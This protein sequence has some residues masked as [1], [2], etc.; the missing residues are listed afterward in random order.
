MVNGRLTK[1]ISYIIL[2]NEIQIQ[3]TAIPDRC[4]GKYGERLR[5][6]AL[7]DQ[8]AV[9]PRLGQAETAAEPIKKDYFELS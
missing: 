8:L 6:A 7:E 5:R 9:S 2:R 4:G 1:N 3:N